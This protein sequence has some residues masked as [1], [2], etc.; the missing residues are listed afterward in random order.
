M[1]LYIVYIITKQYH[2]ST[3]TSDYLSSIGH[4]KDLSYPK[5][6]PPNYNSLVH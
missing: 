1:V 4:V 3:T 5:S 6:T 2:L